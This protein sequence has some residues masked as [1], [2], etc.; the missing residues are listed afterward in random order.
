M[1][2]VLSI[3]LITILGLS[4]CS[5]KALIKPEDHK[6]IE[7]MVAPIIKIDN[8]D[9]LKVADMYATGQEK[10]N[11]NALLHSSSF[12]ISANGAQSMVSIALISNSNYIYSGT[13][14]LEDDNQNAVV[15]YIDDKGTQWSS[16]NGHQKGSNF[17]IVAVETLK[18]GSYLQKATVKVAC[19]VYNQSGAVKGITLYTDIKY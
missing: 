19:F 6:T 17:E 5:K 10:I 14:N 15:S 16:K 11:D 2:K 1:G 18:N 4:A 13:Y 7:N 8:I 12:N 9:Y 3:L